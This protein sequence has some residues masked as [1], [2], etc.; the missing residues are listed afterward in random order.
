MTVSPA[1]SKEQYIQRHER[2]RALLHFNMYKE[3]GVKPEKGK[4]Y[5]LPCTIHDRGRKTS[6]LYTLESRCVSSTQS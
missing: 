3:V 5:K 1:L 4:P 2:V 6:N